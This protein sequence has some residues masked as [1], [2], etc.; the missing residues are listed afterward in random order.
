M[1]AS[2]WSDALQTVLMCVLLGMTYWKLNQGINNDSDLK[3]YAEDMHDSSILWKYNPDPSRKM[4]SLEGGLDLLYTGLIQGALSYTF[5]DPALTDRAFLASKEVM[6][7]AFAFGSLMAIAYIT[8]FGFIGIYG[9]MVASCVEN[10]A[11]PESKLNGATLSSVKDG[12]P[13]YVGTVLGGKYYTLLCLVIITSALSTLDSTFSAVAKV[14][15]PDL[16]GYFRTGAPIDPVL[17]SVGDVWVGR[18]A[19]LVIGVTGTLPMLYEPDELSA[20][21][22]TGTMVPGLGPPIYMAAFA[23]LLST[24][25]SGRVLSSGKQ[26]PIMFL[27]PFCFSASLGTVY[28]LVAQTDLNCYPSKLVDCSTPSYGLHNATACGSYSL[29]YQCIFDSGCWKKTIKDDCRLAE[30]LIGGS[31]SLA[32]HEGDTK[33]ETTVDLSGFEMGEGAY[34]R[35]FGVNVISAIGALGLFIFACGDD[36]LGWQFNKAASANRERELAAALARNPMGVTG[37]NGKDL[38]TAL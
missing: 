32:C 6:L 17:S 15:G 4:W 29:Y 18:F 20:T 1:R 33:Y 5:M 27:L 23:C 36:V 13:S 38:E 30:E 24:K 8:I 11:C 10:G 3:K 21:T 35:L 16:R 22:V 19:I 37:L 31:C 14:V 12:Y 2:L 28:Q 34:R 26:R 9:N 25:L 7:G